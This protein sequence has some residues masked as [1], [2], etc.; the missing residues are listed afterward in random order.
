MWTHAVLQKGA[1]ATEA[2]IQQ[3]NAARKKKEELELESLFTT[4]LPP[5]L[6]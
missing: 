5:P 2:H 4:T 3:D 6:N 1:V